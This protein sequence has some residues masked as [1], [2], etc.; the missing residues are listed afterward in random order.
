MTTAKWLRTVI[1]PIPAEP[2]KE[3]K[4]FFASCDRDV[5]DD[6]VSR[7]HIVLEAIFPSGGSQDICVARSLHT[8]VLMDTIW[9][10]QRRMEALKLYYRVL[11]AMCRAEPHRLQSRNL[12]SLL[13]NE[14]FHRC[15]LAC[16]V[17]LVLSTHKGVEDTS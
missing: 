10:V 9:A 3:L 17:E 14:I 11:D 16:S 1:A 2:S 6:S 4:Q 13:D 12:T 8:A 7:G 5:T 15:M